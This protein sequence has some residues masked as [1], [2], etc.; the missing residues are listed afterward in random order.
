MRF[1]ANPGGGDVSGGGDPRATT[2]HRS[3]PGYAPTQLAIAPST[4]AALGLGGLLVKLEV[5]RFGLPSFKVLGASWATYRAVVDHLGY[6]PEPWSNI[7]ELA[8]RHLAEESAVICE[9]VSV[10]KF[11]AVN[12]K[13]REIFSF[14]LFWTKA[15]RLSC[16]HSVAY[17]KIPHGRNWESQTVY[18]GWYFGEQGIFKGNSR[19]P[20]GPEWDEVI[21]SRESGYW[22]R[23]EDICPF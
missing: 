2:F 16:A 22:G 23:A 11:A 5:E 3:M 14:R 4:A 17:R 8:R 7:N 21:A 6:E 20:P 12:E 13:Y 10:I 19:G 15:M 18:Q 1:H 9:P